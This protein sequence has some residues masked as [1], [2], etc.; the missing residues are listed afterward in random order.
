MFKV[1]SGAAAAIILCLATSPSHA[2]DNAKTL[3]DLAISQCPNL[4]GMAASI[5]EVALASRRIKIGLTEDEVEILAIGVCGVVAYYHNKENP[6]SGSITKPGAVIKP[7][8]LCPHATDLETL[9]WCRS[10]TP[11]ARSPFGPGPSSRQLI[12]ETAQPKTIKTPKRW[13]GECD[14]SALDL[15]ACLDRGLPH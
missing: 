14:E 9:A 15:Q 2:Q 3:K 4:F 12:E 11:P 1:V 6:G 8:A 5:V 13:V 7:E 10:Q